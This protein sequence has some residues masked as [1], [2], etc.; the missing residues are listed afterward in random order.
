M[1]TFDEK[2]LIDETYEITNFVV[3]PFM[4]KYKCFNG[5]KHIIITTHTTVSEVHMSQKFMHEELFEFTHFYNLS[6]RNFQDK[7]CIGINCKFILVSHI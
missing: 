3:T 6:T 1:T 7:H 2:L 5:D 4:G